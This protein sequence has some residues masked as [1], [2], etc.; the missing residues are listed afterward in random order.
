[1]AASF[2]ILSNLLFP[3][4]ILFYAVS[5]VF[6]IWNLMMAQW[7]RCYATSRKVAGSIPDAVTDII[8]FT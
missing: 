1:M 6:G 3:F 8:Q 2:Q 7:L 5:C 4:I